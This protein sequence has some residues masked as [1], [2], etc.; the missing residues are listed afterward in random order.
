M[1]FAWASWFPTRRAYALV[2][3]AA[4]VGLASMLWAPLL[5]VAVAML[6]AVLALL[7]LETVRMFGA[8]VVVDARRIVDERL[9]L[10]EDNPI[11]LIVAATASSRLRVTVIDELPVQLQRRDFELHTELAPGE[12]RSIPYILHPVERGVYAFGAVNVFAS[13]GLH[14]VQRRFQCEANRSVAVHPSVMEMRRAELMAFT[15]RPGRKG[16]HMIRRIGHTMEFEKIKTYVRGDD[17]RSL[18]WKDTARSGELMVN[19]FQDERSQDIYTVLDMGRAM[20]A[21]FEGLT[22]LDHAVNAA[23]AFSNV[24]LR[25]HD[26]AGL[27]TYGSHGGQIIPARHA[28]GQLGLIN[29]ALYGIET[30]FEE[31]NDEHVL[32][33]TRRHLNQRSLLML[34]TNAEALVSLRR[35]M[36]YFR[37]LAKRHVL[38]VVLFENTELTQLVSQPAV[39]ESDIV[40]QT[41]TRDIVFSKQDML[42]ELRHHGVY[43]VVAPPR[44]LSTASINIYLDLKARGV[45]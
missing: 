7:A 11:E 14:L 37:A 20:Y 18:N 34:F 44:D 24:A 9:S 32:A 12:P 29:D 23:L 15:Q 42:R 19:Q 16:Q 43:A 6:C 28:P 21:P 10:G 36:P 41:V 38:V 2:Y 1:K 3:T 8:S 30:E 5:P 13:L 27:I 45:I 22:S 31:T 25:K 39:T 40:L 4:V 33:L 35:R 17:V 26:R